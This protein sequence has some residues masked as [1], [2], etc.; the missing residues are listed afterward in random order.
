MQ[1][2]MQLQVTQASI[3]QLGD[4]LG[5]LAACLDA[6]TTALTMRLDPQAQPFLHASPPPAQQHNPQH[7]LQLPPL[8]QPQRQQQQQIPPNHQPHC[9]QQQQILRPQQ[10]GDA[11]TYDRYEEEEK[12][13]V[14][15]MKMYGNETS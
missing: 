14:F 8:P 11:R 5:T 2:A 3:Q 13:S 6:L 12:H 9:Q 7:Q 4:T 1:T 10:F 15:I